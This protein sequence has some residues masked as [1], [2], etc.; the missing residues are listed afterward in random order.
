MCVHLKIHDLIWDL[1]SKLRERSRS[2]EKKEKK[3]CTEG[4][5]PPPFASVFPA[6]ARAERR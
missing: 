6:P 1:G 2:E 3:E 5:L 4:G